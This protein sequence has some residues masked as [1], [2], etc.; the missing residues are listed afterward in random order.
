MRSPIED[1]VDGLNTLADKALV[2]KL[3]KA[4]GLI[5]SALDEAQGVAKPE[6]ELGEDAEL[7]ALAAELGDDE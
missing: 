7:E 1:A 2:K 3:Q 6:E 5:Q 4:K